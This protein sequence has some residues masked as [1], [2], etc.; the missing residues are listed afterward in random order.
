MFIEAMDSASSK[1]SVVPIALHNPWS[2]TIE[3]T[4]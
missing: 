1:P 3:K 4:E 2:Q